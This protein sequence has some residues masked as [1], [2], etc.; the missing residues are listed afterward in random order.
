MSPL[1]HWIFTIV[2]PGPP[3]PPSCCPPS[4]DQAG[5]SKQFDKMVTAPATGWSPKYFGLHHQMSNGS[6]GIAAVIALQWPVGEK[7]FE[8]PPTEDHLYTAAGHLQCNCNYSYS[9]HCY[10]SFLRDC[11]ERELLS[12][13]NEIFFTSENQPLILI[14]SY[15]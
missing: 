2:H 8:P 6:T 4:N 5:L 13:S 3:P 11:T 7:T 14:S 10:C 12:T 9:N 1:V 15:Y